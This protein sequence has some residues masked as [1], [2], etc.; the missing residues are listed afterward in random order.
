ERDP[1][2]LAAPATV[3]QLRIDGQPRAQ[4]VA[5]AR[6]VRMPLG[7]KVQIA[8][9]DAE[10][11]H[12]PEDSK[13]PE[14]PPSAPTSSTSAPAILPRAFPLPSSGWSWMA[15]RSCWPSWRPTRTDASARCS[16]ARSR[17]AA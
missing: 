1:G 5:G 2:R 8:D 10:V 13:W 3:D 6:G 4:R 11:T 17:L 7:G 15:V 12:A 14:L 16:P 9:A